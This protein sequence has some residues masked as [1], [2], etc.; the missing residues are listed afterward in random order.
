MREISTVTKNLLIINGL[1]F[2]LTQPIFG[3]VSAFEGIFGFSPF[4]LS[5]FYP[6]H[7]S[8]EPFQIATSM[9]MH[10]S[11]MHLAFNMYGLYMFGTIVENVL[12]AKRFLLFYILC[13]LG[14]TALHFAFIY[15]QTLNLP[16][17]ILTN[18]GTPSNPIAIP[19]VGAS[20]A[21]YGLLV[22]FA[23]IAPNA[24]LQLIFPPI[25]LKAKYFVMLLAAFDLFA[26]IS[27]F[28]TGIAHF[29]H[30][31]GALVAFII[32]TI[33]DKTGGLHL[34]NKINRWN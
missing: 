9:F 24:V 8:F 18:F 29:A 3:N 26:G 6:S 19:M 30:L 1:M 21:I 17:E 16:P 13:G 34:K 27:S 28:N 5:V 11:L 15:I 2:L 31:G 33:W 23:Y 4:F 32:L 7:P 22:A 10:G 25:A 14:A 12:G 20:G